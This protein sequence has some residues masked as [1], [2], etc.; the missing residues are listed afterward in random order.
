MLNRQAFDVLLFDLL[1]SASTLPRQGI[2]LMGDG[3]W[4]PIIRWQV[5]Q[6]QGV[7]LHRSMKP[8]CKIRRRTKITWRGQTSN[9]IISQATVNRLR[10]QFRMCPDE[11]HVQIEIFVSPALKIYIRSAPP[12]IRWR[13]TVYAL[14]RRMLH[15]NVRIHPQWTIYPQQHIIHTREELVPVGI[16]QSQLPTFVLVDAWRSG[17]LHIRFDVKSYRSLHTRQHVSWTKQHMGMIYTPYFTIKWC[18]TS[19][20]LYRVMNHNLGVIPG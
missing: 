5:T 11:L 9:Q 7:G 12:V 10:I 16:R 17:I 13:W 15:D 14:W 2:H 20:Y 6:H 8:I 19:I 4:N 1:H 18:F 3:V